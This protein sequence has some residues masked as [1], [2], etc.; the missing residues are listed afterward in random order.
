[1]RWHF[2]L[3]IGVFGVCLVLASSK[4][5]FSAFTPYGTQDAANRTRACIG[6]STVQTV[7]TSNVSAASTQLGANINYYIECD[8]DTYLT[9]DS[10][11]PTATTSKQLL[12]AKTLLPMSTGDS[13][14]RYVAF[15]LASSTSTCRISSCL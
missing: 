11:A 3:A 14:G 4:F 12:P 6:T 10:T 1:M 9:W 13:A 2:S 7:A 5:A 15:I 8:V